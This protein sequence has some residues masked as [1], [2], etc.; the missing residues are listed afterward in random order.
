LRAWIVARLDPLDAE[1]PS[2][3][4]VRS[5]FDLNRDREPRDA[6]P[7]KEAAVL[8]ALVERPEGLSVILTRRS[9]TLRSHTGQVALPGGRC[10][11]GETPWDAAL[12]EAEEEI[13]LDPAAVTLAG[14]STPYRTGSGYHVTPV[15]GFLTPPVRLAPNPA[16]VADIFETP[17][18]FVMDAANHE[19]R[20]GRTPAGDTRAFYAI[21]WE[22]RLI[23]GATAGMLRALHDRLQHP[24]PEAGH[25]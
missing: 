9:D 16:E 11:P 8:I 10:D 25:G 15:V 3:H 14:L 7:Y 19:R 22:E 12:R 5:D 23:W 1:S 20:E 6:S 18:A 24:P 17:F 4:G 2:R 13:G 21:T